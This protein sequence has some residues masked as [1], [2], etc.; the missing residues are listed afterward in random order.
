M[1]R[2]A[3]VGRSV[4]SQDV[5]ALVGDFVRFGGRKL[6]VVI[7]LMLAGGFFEGIGLAMLVPVFALLAPQVGG[8]WQA[9]VDEVLSGI[10]VRD[11]NLQLAVLLGLFCVLVGVRAL[12]LAARDRH[13]S[14][15][16]LGFVDHRRL[17]AVTDLAHARWA[18][19][20][21]L[22]YARIG[23]I[24][25]SEIG[26]LAMACSLML[27]ILMACIMLSAQALLMIVVSPRVAVMML[28]LALLGAL[29]L[30]PLSRRAAVVGKSSARFGFRIAGEA[31]QFLGG[32]K[33]A[34]V[35][36][37]VDAFVAQIAHEGAQ[38]RA[39]QDEQQL[40]Q[41]HA[42]I[43]GAT[44]AAMLGAAMILGA[45]LVGASTVTLLAA[46]VIL[47]RMSGP[48]RSLQLSIQQL[49]GVLP[50]FTALRAL[51]ADLGAPAPYIRAATTNARAPSC[52][53][54]RFDRVRFGYPGTTSP[55]FRAI[56]VTIVPGTVVGITGPSGAGKTTFLDLLTGLLEPGEGRIV[57]DDVPLGPGMLVDWRRR[58]AYVAQDSYLINDTI[59]RNLAWTAESPPEVELWNALANAGA[60]ELVAAMPEGLDTRVEERGTRLSGGERQRIALARALL[61]RPA[62]LILD[63]ATNAIDVATEGTVL[64]NMRCALP[65]ATI[66]VVAHRAE[67][68]RFCERVIDL[69]S[70]VPGDRGAG[71]PLGS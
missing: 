46:L 61:R 23:H 16:S 35:H 56:D 22:E 32:L 41:S 49:F 18:A 30:L 71:P 9:R 62:L 48:V 66:L 28:C 45:V 17:I 21:R 36:D 51:Q 10:G 42:T 58:L 12:V 4:L 43:A 40:L 7:M 52:G 26:R 38:L 63:E 6:V 60:A 47:L 57:I 39:S 8:R 3:R 65:K 67:T 68:L 34:V 15:L 37:T 55:V 69:A 1:A 24:L 2:R 64:A 33:I 27:Y 25:S 14:D 59:R 31:A 13:V 54:I 44:I 20:S 70:L 53:V 5:T 29:A 50:A 19:L 11:H